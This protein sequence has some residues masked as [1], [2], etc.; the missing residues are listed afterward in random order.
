MKTNTASRISESEDK[1]VSNTQSTNSTPA[2]KLICRN[3]VSLSD[4]EIQV[5]L[6]ALQPEV[7]LRNPL[8]LSSIDELI[9]LLSET[10]DNL[11]RNAAAALGELGPKA[12]RSVPALTASL[13]DPDKKVRY[14]AATALGQI[15][16]HGETAIPALIDLIKRENSLE[17]ASP[18]YAASIS[19]SRIAA[20]KPNSVLSSLWRESSSTHKVVRIA[21]CNSLYQIGLTKPQILLP[22]LHRCE[23]SSI[24]AIRQN[25]RIIR[26]SLERARG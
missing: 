8:R 26:N 5:Y 2:L 13:H 4:E 12:R 21:A 7:L 6:F 17:S 9:E 20:H 23:E 15:G 11:R 10:D 22:S 14:S 3:S 16:A 1:N 24:L 18:V 25:A 19:L